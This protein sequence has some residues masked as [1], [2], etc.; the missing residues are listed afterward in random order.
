MYEYM[1][2]YLYV[3]IHRYQYVNSITHV[4]IILL[5]SMRHQGFFFFFFTLKLLLGREFLCQCPD[6]ILSYQDFSLQ[7][8][9]APSDMVRP[10]LFNSSPSESFQ[11]PESF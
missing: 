2:M 1:Y 8:T 10:R 5:N 3:Y 11:P 7:L 6:E 4:D 9:F